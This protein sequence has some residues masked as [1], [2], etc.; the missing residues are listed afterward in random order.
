MYFAYKDSTRSPQLPPR[1]ESRR[2]IANTD[3]T[4][5]SPAGLRETASS[6][7]MPP[8]EKI[9]E[10]SPDAYLSKSEKPIL[11]MTGKNS[12]CR[13]IPRTDLF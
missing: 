8:S 1:I 2:D 9:E 4:N 10:S 12:Y 11:P 3:Q 6:D 7:A 13:F 5:V